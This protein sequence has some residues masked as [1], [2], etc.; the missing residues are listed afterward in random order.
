VHQS[1]CLKLVL[2]PYRLQLSSYHSKPFL[3]LAIAKRNVSG[4]VRNSLMCKV[5]CVLSYTLV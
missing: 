2:A 3:R 4:C 1:H 5:N